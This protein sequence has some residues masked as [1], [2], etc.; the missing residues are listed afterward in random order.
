MLQ[1]PKVIGHRGA[2][3]YA[4]ENT[5]ASFREARRRGASWVEFDVKL[6][7]DGTPI[8]MHDS[9]LKRTLGLDRPASELSW[10]EIARLDAGS[11]F[12]PQFTG[13]P[14]PSFEQAIACLIELGLG[15]NVE[16]KPCAGREV[17]TA[18]AAVE[19]LRRPWRALPPILLSSFK[20]ASLAAAY[21]A[22]PEFDRAIL[23]DELGDDWRGRAEAV[24][25][26]GVNTNGKMLTAGRAAE[27]KQAGYTLSVYTIN[28]PAQARTLAARG[29]DCVITDVPDVVLA[30]L[31]DGAV[32]GAAI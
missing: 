29:V 27:V 20:D 17:E 10:T 25:A 23:I 24:S 32:A 7:G 31:A 6:A 21:A 30:A 28:D 5:L 16:I 8:L 22:A 18:E 19:M 9:S 3:A 15:A 26:A 2:A 14:V 1:L 12:G 13:E 11:W 4:P